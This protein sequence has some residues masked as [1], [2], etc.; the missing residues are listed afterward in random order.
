MDTNIYKD[1]LEKVK[2][3]M[4]FG[5]VKKRMEGKEYTHP[6]TFLRDVRTVFDNAKL[7]NK[8][9]SDVHVMAVTLSEKF[10]EKYASTVASRVAE[11]SSVAEAETMA[12]RRRY[13]TAA[14][15][16]GGTAREAAESR[17]A[18][19]IK[20]IDQV[21]SCIADAKSAAAALCLPVGRPEKEALA[22]ALGRLPQNQFEAAIGIVMH[23]HPGLQPF[24]EVGFDI[25]MLDAL[26]LRQLASFVA[27]AAEEVTGGSGNPHGSKNA[28][29][30]AAN[31]GDDLDN[32]GA[33]VSG[34]EGIKVQWPAVPVGSGLRPFAGKR[35]KKGGTTTLTPL[36][37]GGGDRAAA[38]PFQGGGPDPPQDGG[39]AVPAEPIEEPM[40]EPMDGI[41]ET[42]SA[43]M[44]AVAVPA[45]ASEVP[46]VAVPAA[47]EEEDG[48]KQAQQAGEEGRFLSEVDGGDATGEVVSEDVGLAIDTGD[49][50]ALEVDKN[51]MKVE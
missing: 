2:I 31:Q 20:Y 35:R 15:A 17:A 5:T 34:R 29:N 48:A 42:P 41:E 13:A 32:G 3:P 44:L 43:A 14:A 23:H 40:N 49:A 47:E 26:T 50:A 38:T 16:V 39:G 6:D 24:D 18:F 37:G 28:P 12:A 46:V 21:T 4:D 30:S 36:T 7:Y 8:P 45:A 25:D 27:A 33:G 19:L 11:E 22:A 1:Y 9:G 51:E 10:E